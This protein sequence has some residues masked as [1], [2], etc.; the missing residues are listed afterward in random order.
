MLLVSLIMSNTDE[1]SSVCFW[2][3]ICNGQRPDMTCLKNWKMKENEEL[4]STDYG[5][6]IFVI[7]KQGSHNVSSSFF[8]IKLM[9]KREKKIIISWINLTSFLFFTTCPFWSSYS[10]AFCLQL[11]TEASLGLNRSATTCLP[12]LSLLLP[13]HC[14]DDLLT[15]LA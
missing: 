12:S 14:Q 6:N 4:H 10:A 7:I 1:Y 5:I 8:N 3:T 13:S 15:P 2:A 9:K 11:M